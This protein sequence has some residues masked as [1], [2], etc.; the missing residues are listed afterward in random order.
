MGAPP[1][2][3][4]EGKQ[5]LSEIVLLLPT[6]LQFLLS[7]YTV[8]IPKFTPTDFSRFVK[9]KSP[10]TEVFLEPPHPVRAQKS[11]PLDSRPAPIIV[12]SPVIFDIT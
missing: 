1:F 5:Q 11:H 4:A 7:G 6:G 3:G 10:V 12:S 2:E 8:Y 9:T